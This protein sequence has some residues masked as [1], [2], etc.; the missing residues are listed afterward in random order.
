LGREAIQS[1]KKREREGRCG[2]T[3]RTYHF[4]GD[5]KTLYSFENSIFLS[6]YSEVGNALL[7]GRWKLHVPPKFTYIFRTL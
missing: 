7:D 6:N 5:L 3:E 1:E 2:P 4:Q